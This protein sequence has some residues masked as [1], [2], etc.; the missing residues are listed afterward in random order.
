M[1]SCF[2]TNPFLPPSPISSPSNPFATPPAPA[3][4]TNIPEVL[5][6]NRNLLEESGWYHE[7]L[8]WSE[9]VDLLKDTTEG[10]FLVRDSAEPRFL[11][12]LSVQR[13]AGK[14]PTSVRIH[15]AHG[16][17]W[18]DAEE[19]IQHLMPKFDTVVDL[20]GH[21]LKLSASQVGKSHVWVDNS[22]Q[23]DSPICLTRPLYHSRQPPS[24]A[25]FA[26]LAINANLISSS[27]SRRTSGCPARYAGSGSAAGY[28][29]TTASISD[30]AIP[31]RLKTYLTNYPYKM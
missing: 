14:G 18:L 17:F 11:F 26:R 20:I 4:M 19:K 30:L 3:P 10:T 7:K 22:G 1:T 28:A 23:L 9:S 8:S 15:F 27:N 24:L 16:K 6:R 2:S 21:Y 25:H 5:S 31:N 12:T 13:S 29:A